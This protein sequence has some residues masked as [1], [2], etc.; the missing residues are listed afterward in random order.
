[1]KII[2][3]LIFYSMLVYCQNKSI[4]CDSLFYFY[5]QNIGRDKVPELIGGMDSLLSR[6]I[7]PENARRNKIEGKVYILA[8][9]DEAG[10]V[11]CIKVIKRLGI[12]CDEEALR[13]INTSSFYPASLRNKPVTCIIAIP[14]VFSLKNK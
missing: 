7:Y 12:G 3:V 8:I 11:T 13:L 9:I 2:I 1:M 14:L 5:S 4:N 6:L 10:N